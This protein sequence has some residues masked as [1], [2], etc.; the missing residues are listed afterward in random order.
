MIDDVADPHN[1]VDSKKHLPEPFQKLMVD[2]DSPI[3]D[4]YPPD[5]EIDMNGKKMAWQ[6]IALLPF[7]SQDRLLGALATVEPLLTPDEKRRNTIGD[8][9]ML[10]SDDNDLYPKF[11][12]LYTKKKA[13]RVSSERT[14]RVSAVLTSSFIRRFRLTAKS[15]GGYVEPSWTT[16]NAFQGQAWTRL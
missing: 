1:M 5:F 4:F 6:G 14:S 3:L 8:N 11:C 15:P 13:S 12:E 7:I 16:R 9:V 2:E 10:I